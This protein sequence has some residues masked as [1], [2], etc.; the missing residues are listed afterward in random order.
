MNYE[1]FEANVNMWS[2]VR[3]IY[4]QLT[5]QSQLRLYYDET[6]ECRTAKDESELKMEYG[7]RVV[8]LINCA[9]MYQRS[10]WA[11]MNGNDYSREHQL[12]HVVSCPIELAIFARDF[13]GAIALVIEEIDDV[14]LDYKECFDLTWEKISKREG[15]IVGSKYVKYEDLSADQRLEVS[16]RMEEFQELNS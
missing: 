10:G 15:M 3:G 9:F 14:G 16:R 6:F 8:C 5:W 4:D 12:L 11:G 1:E 7:D 13:K 2:K